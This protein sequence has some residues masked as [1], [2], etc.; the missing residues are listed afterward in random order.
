MHEFHT[1]GGPG[2]TLTYSLRRRLIDTRKEAG[3]SQDGIALRLGVDRSTVA[4]WERGEVHPKRASVW[5]WALATG[6]DPE[7]LWTGTQTTPPDGNPAFTE[8]YTRPTLLL[9]A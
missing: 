5:G 3:L 9:A 6:F 4:R 1:A 7:W 8:G 2:R